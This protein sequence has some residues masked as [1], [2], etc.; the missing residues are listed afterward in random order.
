MEARRGELRR[1]AHDDADNPREL[2]NPEKRESLHPASDEW[3]DAA[4]AQRGR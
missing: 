4:Q 1:V 2:G 3:E